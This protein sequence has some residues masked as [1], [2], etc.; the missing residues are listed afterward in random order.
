M[1]VVTEREIFVLGEDF[2]KSIGNRRAS[3]CR[4][5][6]D[7]V[8]ENQLKYRTLIKHSPM[9][10]IMVTGLIKCVIAKINSTH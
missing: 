10:T 8:A 7:V 2:T 1:S 4:E 5:I 9:Y 3:W 6:L